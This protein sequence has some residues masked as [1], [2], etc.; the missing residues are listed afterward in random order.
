MQVQQLQC[1]QCGG[2]LD[3]GTVSGGLVQCAYCGARS[4]LSQG[5]LRNLGSY[6]LPE[7]RT[8]EQ[9]REEM[10][11]KLRAAGFTA[12]P[13]LTESEASIRYLMRRGRARVKPLPSSQGG[14][15]ELAKQYEEVREGL[16]G[17]P[18]SGEEDLN[19]I[20]LEDTSDLVAIEG[21]VPADIDDELLRFDD[22]IQEQ[23]AKDLETRIYEKTRPLSYA[24]GGFDTRTAWHDDVFLLDIPVTEL[25]F[26]A[27]GLKNSMFKAWSGRNPKGEYE[28]AYNRHDGTALRWKVPHQGVNW[29]VILLLFLLVTFVLPL[30][31][32]FA[33]T[34]LGIIVGVAL[35]MLIAVVSLIAGA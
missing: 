32:T 1:P 33:L 15:R 17:L 6:A 22:R 25:S 34:F 20:Y 24:W 18:L 3:P 13:D 9:L 31:G 14:N 4:L 16:F 28:A 2:Q 11:L 21:R 10:T 5:R 35:P 23:L 19:L 29:V 27:P 8:V 30:V 7:G 12:I 26:I